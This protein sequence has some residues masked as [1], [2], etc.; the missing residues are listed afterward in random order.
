MIEANETNVTKNLLGLC[1]SSV[2]PTVSNLNVFS[3][4]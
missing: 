1:E 2:R 3:R 4:F